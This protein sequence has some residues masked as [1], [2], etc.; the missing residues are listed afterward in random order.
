[1]SDRS[2]SR[3]A[4]QARNAEKPHRY[5]T[6]KKGTRHVNLAPS[7]RCSDHR[8]LG[9]KR[10]VGDHA[11]DVGLGGGRDQGRGSAPADSEKPETR[12]IM[13]VTRPQVGQSAARRSSD[14]VLGR[15]L[16]RSVVRIEI[17]GSVIAKVEREE[18]VAEVAE[19]VEVGMKAPA[20]AQDIRG[21]R[22]SRRPA[23]RSAPAD[24]CRA[25]R[26]PSSVMNST[27]FTALDRLDL[28]RH[29][30]RLRLKDAGDH[31]RVLDRQIN[32]GREPQQQRDR[33]ARARAREN[34]LDRP[35][36]DALLTVS[37]RRG[38]VARRS[39]ANRQASPGRARCSAM[40]IA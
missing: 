19:M 31:R 27:G 39:T 7:E 1:M 12:R 34:R 2:A 25:S 22:R 24:N 8:S 6:A 3:R 4:V 38:S 26:S 30:E 36:T 10:T 13:I 20:V 29:E 23:L 16:Q 18:V 17:A 21:N 37:L 33:A 32:H 40:T 11:P 9:G 28:E 35:I 14:L 5:E 15:P